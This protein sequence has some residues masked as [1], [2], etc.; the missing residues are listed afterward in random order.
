VLRVFYLAVLNKPEID[1]GPLIS[2]IWA[3]YFVV[4]WRI[5]WDV[6]PGFPLI[7][8]VIGGALGLGFYRWDKR[9]E[10][11]GVRGFTMWRRTLIIV[12]LVACV[13][14]YAHLAGVPRTL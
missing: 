1:R 7:P 8:A 5:I 4:L 6:Y 2:L 3:I 11:G 13:L 12:V 9:F 14:L 10:R